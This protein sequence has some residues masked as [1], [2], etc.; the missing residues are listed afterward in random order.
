MRGCGSVMTARCA[1]GAR[2]NPG[3]RSPRRPEYFGT[4]I[5]PVAFTEKSRTLD[6]KNLKN[7]AA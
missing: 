7:G 2:V 5:S 6:L 3:Q 4:S 1:P